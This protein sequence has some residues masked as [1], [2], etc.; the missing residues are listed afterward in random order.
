MNVPKHKIVLL[1][2][3]GVGKTS[4]LFRIRYDLY[5]KDT[6][7]TVGCE[8]VGFHHD[9]SQMKLLIWDT[10]GQEKFRAFTPQFCRNAKVALVFYDPTAPDPGTAIESWL[11]FVD[12]DCDVLAV[13]TKA[14][15][16]AGETLNP[17]MIKSVNGSR[18][19]YAV[20]ISSKL[21]TGLK[22]LLQQTTGILSGNTTRQLSE[23]KV[24]IG[25]TDK[26]NRSCCV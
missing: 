23:A 8:F 14:D 26:C 13:P 1:G 6:A 4:M 17:P 16:Y 25:S 21:N 19:H 15:L 11:T 7:A 5:R 2:E 18:V 24:I 10:A 12:K 3:S 20:P 9:E 22:E